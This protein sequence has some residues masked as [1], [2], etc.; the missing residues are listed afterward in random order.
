MAGRYPITNLPDTPQNPPRFLL[1]GR[2]PITN[3]S[4]VA[5][6][7][8][9][10]LLAGCYPITNL[11]DAP[12]FLLAGHYPITNLPDFAQNPPRLLIG[13]HPVGKL[14][15]RVLGGDADGVVRHSLVAGHHRRVA[16]VHLPGQTLQLP[17]IVGEFGGV[18]LRRGG[19][20]Y[21]SSFFY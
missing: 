1:A 5:E 4:D 9:R 18:A 15:P 19:I 16:D 10:L 21:Y 11:P 13:R 8:S 2:Y 6:N 14:H 7:A 17:Q 20:C 12:R 3:L